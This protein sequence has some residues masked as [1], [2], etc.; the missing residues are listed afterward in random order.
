MSTL[1][2]LLPDN[3]QALLKIADDTLVFDGQTFVDPLI[4]KYVM[5]HTVPINALSLTFKE[6]ATA[7]IISSPFVRAFVLASAST[8]EALT[9]PAVEVA[10]D[11]SLGTCI[12]GITCRGTLLQYVKLQTES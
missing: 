10:P 11:P 7:F 1:L 4:A 5:L 8:S 2:V 12:C 3:T 9:T 6:A